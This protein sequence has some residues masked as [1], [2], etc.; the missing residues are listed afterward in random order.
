MMDASQKPIWVICGYGKNVVQLYLSRHAFQENRATHKKL[1][2]Y[3]IEKIL[4]IITF[5]VPMLGFHR[6]FET[7]F[8][9]DLR[10]WSGNIF[11]II[12]KEW[13]ARKWQLAE[14]V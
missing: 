4:A 10:L 3:M 8:W 12:K 2:K 13:E 5:L 1:K 11:W 9:R 6:F 14:M 7:R